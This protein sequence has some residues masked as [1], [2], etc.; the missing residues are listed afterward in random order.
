MKTNITTDAMELKIERIGSIDVDLG[1]VD[2][3]F[4]ITRRDDDLDID[5]LQEYMLAI[6]YRDT[7][8]AGGYFCHQVTVM[9]VP[10]SDNRAICIVHHRHDI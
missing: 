5:Q 7:S 6:Y 3:Y 8:I 1:A 9:P 4:V 2:E 10:Y